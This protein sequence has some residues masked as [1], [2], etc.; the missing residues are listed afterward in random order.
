MYTYYY[1]IGTIPHNDKYCIRKL[2]YQDNILEKKEN[3]SI[4][5]N[6]LNVLLSNISDNQYKKYDTNS[7]EDISD[8]FFEEN[9][10]FKPGS[11][12]E[13]LLIRNHFSR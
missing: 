4:N 6:K 3:F 12:D 5:I 11:F 9:N 7:L 1:Q 8:D 2:I 13:K 10:T